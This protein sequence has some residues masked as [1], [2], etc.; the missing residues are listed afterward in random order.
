MSSTEESKA[1]PFATNALRVVRT[2]CYRRAYFLLPVRF[3]ANGHRGPRR[4]AGGEPQY[5]TRDTPEDHSPMDIAPQGQAA[6][7]RAGS[8]V[9][10]D[11]FVVWCRIRLPSLTPELVP[12][13]V[14]VGAEDRRD[15]HPTVC[16]KYVCAGG[17][18]QIRSQETAL[19]YGGNS[20]RL[21][22]CRTR[23]QSDA[24]LALH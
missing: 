5:E 15:S 22:N 11:G 18:F 2:N 13:T 14:R 10:E 3:G 16:I 19:C 1:P 4:S 7:R 21:Y 6:E 12:K 17:G 23:V 9:C 8:R 24:R 20:N